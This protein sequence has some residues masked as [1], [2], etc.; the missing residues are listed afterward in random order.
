MEWVI[1][2]L[3]S[4]AF[5]ALT[6]VFY[7]FLMTKKFQG[8]FSM[9]SY[10]VFI[11]LIFCL[12]LYLVNP[13]SFLFP[14]V[15]LAT[16]VGLLPLL[17]FWFYSK[18]LMV[19][20]VSRITPL[21]QLIPIFVVLLSY[22]FLNENLVEQSCLGIAIMVI[23]SVLISYKKT[24]TGSSISSALKFMIPC[25][26]V[27]SIDIILSK[28]LLGYLDYWSILFWY[29]LGSFC[30]VLLLLTFSKPRK[31]FVESVPV[32]GKRTFFVALVG[33]CL[34]FLSQIFWLIAAS[35]ANV[36]SV[37]ALAGLE[38]FYVFGFMLFLSLFLPKIL[39][40]DVRKDVIFLKILSI[41]L[42]F[43]GTFLLAT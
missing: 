35:L 37:S 12:I 15:I 33:E 1:F 13:I 20:E 3:L 19:E 17:Q 39:K 43:I 30:G 26:L 28:F 21:L 38:P 8:Y 40:E 34:Y 22:F 25:N 2:A 23:A 27:A 6:T 11:D 31:E 29:L 24:K 18:A 42:M 14:Y 36:S 10:L 5:V 7:K 9:L 16:M 4:P 41:A 32:V